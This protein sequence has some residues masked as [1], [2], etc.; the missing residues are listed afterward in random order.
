MVT[1]PGGLKVGNGFT[2]T[3]TVEVLE[4]AP[5]RAVTVKVVTPELIVGVAVTVIPVVELRRAAGFQV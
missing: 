2:V 5:L 3:L 1:E 4:H